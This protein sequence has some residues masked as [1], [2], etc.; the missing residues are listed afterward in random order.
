[1]RA[2]QLTF[3]KMA[4]SQDQWITYFKERKRFWS[5]KKYVSTFNEINKY[6]RDL[7]KFWCER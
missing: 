4:S 1:M 2:Q 6:W 3:Y 7:K 5:D